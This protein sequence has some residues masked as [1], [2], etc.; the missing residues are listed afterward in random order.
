M[1][2]FFA[3]PIWRKL[4]D[5]LVFVVCILL[6]LLIAVAMHEGVSNYFDEGIY[7]WG[8]DRECVGMRY[9]S[10]EEYV[11]RSFLMALLLLPFFLLTLLG[12]IWRSTRIKL[13]VLCLVALICVVRPGP[14][15]NQWVK[16]IV[17]YFSTFFD[18]EAKVA[19]SN[20]D[21][22]VEYVRGF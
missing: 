13:L 7:C 8:R 19:L 17:P 11:V 9:P 22:F 18:L 10:R 14:Y 3:K 20:P 4:L 1:L 2:G 5:G 21:S 16:E 12:L 15:I 6:F